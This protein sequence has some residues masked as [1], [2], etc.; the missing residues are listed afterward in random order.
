MGHRVGVQHTLDDEVCILG[1]ALIDLLVELHLDF[2][3]YAEYAVTRFRGTH[4]LGQCDVFDDGEHLARAQHLFSVDSTIGDG[5]EFVAAIWPDVAVVHIDNGIDLCH[6]RALG[7]ARRRAF[8][9][10]MDGCPGASVPA[11]LQSYG[12]Q[13]L[14][15]RLVSLG[16]HRQ[17]R[18]AKRADQFRADRKIHF[19]GLGLVVGRQDDVVAERPLC[20]GIE[21]DMQTVDVDH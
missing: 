21:A 4:E 18:V 14:A 7:A 20:V 15:V 8:H 11:L 10:T 13:H 2:V 19:L 17:C 16:S 12:V 6:Q 5:P 9:P 1:Q 3:A